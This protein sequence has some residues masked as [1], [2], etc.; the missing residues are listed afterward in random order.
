MAYQLLLRT[1]YLLL[2]PLI[3]GRAHPV[4]LTMPG[5]TRLTQEACIALQAIIQFS[6]VLRLPQ[7]PPPPF[8]QELPQPQAPPPSLT[9]FRAGLTQIAEEIRQP[10]LPAAQLVLGAGSIKVPETQLAAVL[11]KAAYILTA[12]FVLLPCQP[13]L[14]AQ[15]APQL[16][17][18]PLPDVRQ[19]SVVLAAHKLILEVVNS[20]LAPSKQGPAG[21]D[22]LEEV[23]TAPPSLVKAWFLSVQTGVEP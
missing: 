15:P 9:V 10:F 19:G 20:A 13:P 14:R 12:G 5:Y 23:V 4:N 7:Q 21:E 11:P 16:L 3:Q 8:L 22:A 1:I 18:P 6:P 2:L 17:P